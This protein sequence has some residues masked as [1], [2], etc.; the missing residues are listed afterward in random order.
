LARSRRA[1][2]RCCTVRWG[3]I[4]ISSIESTQSRSTDRAVALTA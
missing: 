2:S 4:T 3:P 1:S